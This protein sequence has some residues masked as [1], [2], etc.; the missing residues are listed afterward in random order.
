M[1]ERGCNGGTKAIRRLKTG[2][3]E[4]DAAVPVNIFQIADRSRGLGRPRRFAL[5]TRRTV[6]NPLI[7]AITDT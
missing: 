2:T 1:A 4:A 3:A 5:C 7:P 6:E